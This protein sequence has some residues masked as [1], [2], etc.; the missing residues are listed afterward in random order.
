[1]VRLVVQG[2]SKARRSRSLQSRLR[3]R[4]EVR[5]PHEK[6]KSSVFPRCDMHLLIYMGLLLIFVNNSVL[7]RSAHRNRVLSKKEELASFFKAD[8]IPTIDWNTT[9][10]SKPW[11]M[12]YHIYIP[13]NNATSRKKSLDIVREQ[14]RDIGGSFVGGNG[15]SD[16]DSQTIV[17]YSTVGGTFED[18]WMGLL[19]E[20]HEL[21]CREIGRYETG[22][23]T[24]T[25]DQ[26]RNFCTAHPEKLVSYT[27]TKGS[28]HPEG[29][30]GPGN[31]DRWR[32]HMTAAAT[33]QQ[34]TES[35]EES[36]STCNA[37]GLLF[38]PF[39]SEHFPGN[40]WVAK[41]SYVKNLLPSKKLRQKRQILLDNL[42]G[43]GLWARLFPTST[44]FVGTDRYM[45]E[46]WVGSS[47]NITPCDVSR[48]LH[49]D[50][51][52]EDTRNTTQD[53]EWSMAPRFPFNDSLAVWDVNFDILKK[54]HKRMR[55]YFLLPGHLHRWI[56]E[57]NATP[58]AESWVW[59][60]YLDAQR[61]EKRVRKDGN[62]AVS[63]FIENSLRNMT[64]KE[65]STISI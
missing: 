18:G 3:P 61:W 1:M 31:Q 63:K 53:F 49:M 46:H 39:P 8:S 27:H 6:N 40:A 43:E 29:A 48:E 10:Y 2:A 65:P 59:S 22:H 58:S 35:L 15:L 30:G 56:R 19:C 55:E 57:Y 42:R 52:L 4:H 28:F 60:W 54:P 9:T 50:Y 21:D 34:C 12:F 16:G 62:L 11:V 44:A 51:W 5:C 47:P 20:Q 36:Q 32:R 37:C 13:L 64:Q 26:V 14:I 7:F 25:L 45:S 23:E 41:C 38:S 33:S 24:L 17:Y